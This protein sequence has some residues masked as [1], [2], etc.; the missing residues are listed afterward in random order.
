MLDS[1]RNAL[2]RWVLDRV[3]REWV[4]YV[5]S[6]TMTDFNRWAN[7]FVWT[8]DHQWLLEHIREEAPGVKTLVFLPNQLWRGFTPG[9]HAPVQVVVNGQRHLRSYSLGRQPRGR[10]S[11]TVK[12]QAGG[13]VSSWLHDELTIG[14]RLTVEPPRGQFVHQGQPKLLFLC[15]G[16]GVTPCHAMLSHWMALPAA[17]RPDVQVMLQFHSQQ[18]IIYAQDW[19]AWRKDGLPVVTGLSQA[20]PQSAN[21]GQTGRLDRE[22]L[23][24]HCPDVAQ[25][26]IYLCGPEGFMQQMMADLEALGADPRR[27]HTERF[28]PMMDASAVASAKAAPMADLE[29]A[30][31]VFA[32]VNARMVL[33]QADQ[34]KSL[35]QLAHERGIA[36]ESGCEQGSCGTC[37]LTL[38][39][40]AVSGNT[41]G[42][43]VYLCTA[44]PAS[45]TLVLGG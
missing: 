30:E 17:D 4:D 45:R 40:G 44:Y 35:L 38:H 33:T 1:T 18:D 15:A 9:Q 16:S 2:N 22:Q 39:E 36:L 5:V 8:Y 12:R 21:D 3:S 29:G 13:L 34:G 25:R 27:I 19:Q 10:V 32:H 28:T 42:R 43:A 6:N 20:S 11:I 14:Q 31:V 37:K 24:Q 41:L 23:R 7:G 26:D